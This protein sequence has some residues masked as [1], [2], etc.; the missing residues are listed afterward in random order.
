MMTLIR[1]TGKVAAGVVPA[2]LVA[3]LGLPELGVLVFVAVL[4]PESAAG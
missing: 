4:A 2:A 3:G 1:W